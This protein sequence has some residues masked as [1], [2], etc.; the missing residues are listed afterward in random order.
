MFDV[1]RRRIFP[2][3]VWC[4]VMV[5]AGWLWWGMHAGSARGYVEGIAYD[6]TSLEPGRIAAIQVVPG[7]HVRAGEVIATLDSRALD[8]EIQSLE[9]ERLK[10]EA[11]LLAAASQ[12]RLDVGQSSREIEETV[13]S[14]E[15]ARQTARAERSV[16][17]AQL[18]ALDKQI[19]AVRELVE[20][21]LADR[22][23]LAAL[24]VE[25]AGLR[26]Q[27]QVAD[28]LIRQL[29]AQAAAAR[30]RREGIPLD[31]GIRAT[32]P[33]R[34]ELE[35]IRGMRAL[36]D[37]RREA[38]TLRAPGP[39]EVSAIYL[40]P[41]ELVV[42]GSIVMTI[43]GPAGQAGHG[44]AIVYVCASE[45]QSAPVRVGE[46][47]ELSPPQGGTAVLTGHVDRLAPAVTLLPE[48][49]WKD[50]R[51]PL[52]GRGIYVMVADAVTLL[53]GQSFAI[54]FTGELSPRASERPAPAVT[55]ADPPSPTGVA[56]TP[57]PSTPRTRA[58][59][60]EP[61]ELAV[62][63]AL[64]AASRFEPSALVW[65]PARAQY[66]VAS[67]DTGHENVD[68][69]APWLFAM[70]ADGTIEPSPIRLRGLE[71]FSDLESIAAAPDGG[72]YLLA[73]Q[74][75]SKKGKRSAA[76]QVFAH[77]AVTAAGADVT[78]HVSLAKLLDRLD[79]QGLA[80]LGL[81]DTA[82]LDIEGM[83]ATREGGLLIGLKAP[84]DLEG[85]PIWH[86]AKPD[87]LLAGGSPSDAGLTLWGHVPLR[88]RADGAEVAGGISE[89]LELPDGRLLVATTASAGDPSTQDGAL[90]VVD[91]RAA[92]GTPTLVRTFPGQKAE[93][94]A[95]VAAGDAI[96]IV[97]DTGAATPL[98]MELRWPAP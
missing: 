71:K 40:R 21:R 51:M 73:S 9:G 74:S 18:A 38:L 27:I 72:V 80:A 65:S 58:A 84:L 33:L 92:A 4:G 8:A 19:D 68:E 48:R 36:L 7:Q 66:L 30:A 3:A 62:P 82:S 61:T 43:N 15:V 52:W 91:G 12:S 24:T 11:E 64:L 97:F 1:L 41:G 17:V 89:L 31:A 45:D 50:P 81:D 75:F 44:P 86:L 49:C 59:K 42:E 53:P 10:V 87:A 69:H 46:G 79:A 77:V 34:A 60:G 54:S 39:G 29:D 67:D 23:D 70:G 13:D 95:L 93:G 20:K 98:W 56:V 22:R 47:V 16:S 57:A 94:L 6:V 85:A 83:T 90:Y 37:V 2:F 78:A 35:V 76:R 25:Q 63:S 32:D 55:Q 96:A 28:G 88:V 14:A 26:K 5:S